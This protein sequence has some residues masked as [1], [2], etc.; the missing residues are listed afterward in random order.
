L[1]P[2]NHFTTPF[3]FK[4]NP[5]PDFIDLLQHISGSGSAV[6]PKKGRNDNRRSL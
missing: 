1:A 3:S 4:R 2:L 5:F 6:D